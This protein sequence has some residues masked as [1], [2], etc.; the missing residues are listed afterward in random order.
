[1]SEEWVTSFMY[2]PS[3]QNSSLSVFQNNSPVADFYCKECNEEFELK[4][5]NG[6]I[7]TKIVDGAYEAMIRRLNSSNNPNFFFLSYDISTY[8]VKNFILIPKHFFV[9]EI[10]EKRKPLSSESK[11]AGWIGCNINLSNIPELGKIFIVEQSKINNPNEVYKK[12]KKSLFVRNATKEARGW[13]I[14]ILSCV[15]RI[16]AK[17]FAL[18]EVYGF[19]KEL[20]V[21][22]PENSF[23]KEKIRQQLQV[24]RDSGI[25]EF[26][27]NGQYRKVRD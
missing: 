2:C 23:V 21:K 3:C 20:Q 18:A 12:W 8:L 19:E 24:L 6:V 5:K 22:Y 26:L 11:R 15:D 13:I 27:G 4:S 7:G 25:I 9:P 1:M 10:I 17:E 14:D 16:E